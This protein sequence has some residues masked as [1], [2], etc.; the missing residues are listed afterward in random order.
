MSFLVQYSQKGISSLS[1]RAFQQID[2]SVYPVLSAMIIFS[3]R[4]EDINGMGLLDMF[5]R[6]ATLIALPNETKLFSLIRFYEES[7]VFLTHH[8]TQENVKSFCLRYLEA[9]K[10]LNILNKSIAASYFNIFRDLISKTMN[11]LIERFEVLE[12]PILSIIKESYTLQH[13]LD[14]KDP[15]FS[16]QYED[17]NNLIK[18]DSTDTNTLLI[19]ISTIC[20]K[21]L[22]LTQDKTCLKKITLSILIFTVEDKIQNASEIENLELILSAS[23]DVF[24][25][26]QYLKIVGEYERLCLLHNQPIFPLELPKTQV[27]KTYNKSANY[28]TNA[29]T[30]PKVINYIQNCVDRIWAGEYMNT[31]EIGNILKSYANDLGE[32]AIFSI[33][34]EMIGRDLPTQRN[35]LSW[36]VIG[37]A[38]K[39]TQV[40]QGPGFHAFLEKI[41]IM[42]SKVSN[43]KMKKDFESRPRQINN[44]CQRK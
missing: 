43:N 3:K 29:T 24:T 37:K 10:V 5:I 1:A 8:L 38:C 17:L 32:P 25:P 36:R 39:Q 26:S 35:Q 13:F 16:L 40:F 20:Q 27:T 12:F 31:V 41:R 15:I 21:L 19:S 44:Y 9:V 7:L 33:I 2:W 28:R 6:M 22:L 34:D 14:S 18:K 30:R 23:A 42:M 11:K 4:L